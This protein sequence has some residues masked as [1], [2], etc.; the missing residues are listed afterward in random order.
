MAYLAELPALPINVSWALIA[1]PKSLVRGLR[2]GIAIRSRLAEPKA[3]FKPVFH[4]LP[5][6]GDM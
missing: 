4:G 5:V 2:P 3:F 1:N 6:E